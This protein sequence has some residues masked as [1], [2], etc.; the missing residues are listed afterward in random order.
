MKYC[1]HKL[2]QCIHARTENRKAQ[3]IQQL[4]VAEAKRLITMSDNGKLLE[5]C[6]CSS[7]INRKIGTRAEFGL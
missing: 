7:T 4:M 3:C 6:T 2:T 1:V 5:K